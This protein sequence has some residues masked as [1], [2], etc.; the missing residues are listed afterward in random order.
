MKN[1]KI[2]INSVLLLIIICTIYFFYFRKNTQEE[3]TTPTSE[4]I[5]IF[6]LADEPAP[7]VGDPNFLKSIRLDVPLESQ[8][9]DEALENGCEITSL[10]MLLRYYGYEVNKNK[11]SDLLNYQP[12]KVEKKYKGDPNLGFV[13]DMKA[14]K[15]AM[16]VYVK[17]IALVAKQI[18]GTEF[19]IVASEGRPFADILQVLQKD[20]PVWILSTVDMQI[21]TEKDFIDWP[22]KTGTLKVTPLIHSVV[23][24]GMD[25]K[26]VYYND[27]YGE[28]NAHVSIETLQEVYE[29][30]GEQALYLK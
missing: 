8:F 4:T 21:P 24:T 18:I 14:G 25:E 23:L 6:G 2:I 27:P 22:T 9:A 28:K 3:E 19:E 1:K 10:S 26:N 11:L 7:L 29:S 16:G 13:G 5:D 20:T 15:Q 12:Y 17:P 30:M